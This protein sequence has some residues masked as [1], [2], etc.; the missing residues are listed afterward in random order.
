M[1]CL[2]LVLPFRAVCYVTFGQVTQ[3][4]ALKGKSGVC[5]KFTY[6]PMLYQGQNIICE[7]TFRQHFSVSARHHCNQKIEQD[8][9]QDQKC[10]H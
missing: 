2:I 6:K 3:Q 4:T 9:V 10:Q 1:Q 7:P 5:T 8:D